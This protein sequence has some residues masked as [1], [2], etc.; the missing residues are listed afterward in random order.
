MA[1]IPVRSGTGLPRGA[2]FKG[3]DEDP[4]LWNFLVIEGTTIASKCL[5]PDFD[6]ERDVDAP[7]Q[8][9]SSRNQLV[10]N[11]LAPGEVTIQILTTTSEQLRNLQDVF[12]K[13][14]SP[15]RPL[16]KQNVVTVGHPS[17]FLRGIRQLYFFGAGA[18]KNQGEGVAP[19]L[20]TFKAKVFDAKTQ[21]GGGGST[22]PKP[23]AAPH[24]PTDKT[25]QSTSVDAVKN[26]VGALYSLGKDFLSQAGFLPAGYGAAPPPTPAPPQLLAP[27]DLKKLQT[28]TGSKS[29][30]FAND[31]LTKRT[32]TR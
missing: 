7:K 5:L 26:Q 22:K 17:F 13:Y 8:K 30:K 32:P 24:G 15:D 3:P 23:S 28:S 10:D 31:V 12:V 29:A 14:M 6:R 25:F 18:P 11:G 9:G 4:E 21:I 27:Q 19:I 20:H 16:T 1:T 2:S